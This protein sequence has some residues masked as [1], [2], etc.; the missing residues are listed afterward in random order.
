[1]EQTVAAAKA[2]LL[3]EE[4]ARVAERDASGASAAQAAAATRVAATAEETA[5]RATIRA[6]SAGASSGSAY[7]YPPPSA[8]AVVDLPDVLNL[9]VAAPATK[10]SNTLLVAA[11]IGLVA[12][13]VLK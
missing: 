13:L 10:K 8:S 4:A 12:Y 7:K 11:G 5:R 2:A 1:M 3:A 6:T 9:P